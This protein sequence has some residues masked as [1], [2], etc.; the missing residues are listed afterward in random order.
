MTYAAI[1]IVFCYNAS[2]AGTRET[3]GVGYSAVPIP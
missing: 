3:N 1:A 2:L